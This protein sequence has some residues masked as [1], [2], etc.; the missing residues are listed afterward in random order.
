MASGMSTGY[1]EAASHFLEPIYFS[2]L[3]SF[4]S[5]FF[6]SLNYQFQQQSN[7]LHCIRL[8]VIRVLPILFSFTPY[9]SQVTNMHLTIPVTVVLLTLAGVVKSATDY[10]E[11]T[12]DNTCG[13]MGAGNN[14]GYRCLDDSIPGMGSCCSSDGYCGNNATYCGKGCQLQYG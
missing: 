10:Y 9:Q 5:F 7:Q 3:S 8:L 2:F 11:Y 4:S 12:K 6:T 1:E 13:I 14:N